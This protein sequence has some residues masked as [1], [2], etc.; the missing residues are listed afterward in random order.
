VCD[1]RI[2]IFFPKIRYNSRG[3]IVLIE[4]TIHLYPKPL[5]IG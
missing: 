1:D 2:P 5:L 4:D 3:E